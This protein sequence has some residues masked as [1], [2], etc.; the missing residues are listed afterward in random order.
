MKSRKENGK[1]KHGKGKARDD[2][3][4]DSDEDAEAYGEDHASVEA[5]GD[6]APSSHGHGKRPVPSVVVSSGHRVPSTSESASSTRPST[7]NPYA[8]YL[9]SDWLPH[10]L[11]SPSP[12]HI[13]YPHSPHPESTPS[14]SLSS[15]TPQSGYA[16]ARGM[17]PYL[18]L[19][20]HSVVWEHTLDVVVQMD[21][22]RDTTDLLPNELKLVVMQVR[23]H[24]SH[25]MTLYPSFACPLMS[26]LRTSLTDTML[27]ISPFTQRVI[28]GDID[29]PHN[30]RLG[31]VYLNL[32]EYADVGP[33]TR[34]YLLS[35]SKTNATL[36]ASGFGSTHSMTGKCLSQMV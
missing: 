24:D 33:I 6:E 16:P 26:F 30:P 22:N 2:G 10:S 1:E 36:K 5:S 25:I 17:T 32:A 4:L 8:Q 19:Q 27:T 7:P 3:N 34:R 13:S 11:I 9:S 21:V 28:P 18:K 12:S 29:A 15:C 23:F 14:R 35:Q 31:A 20:D